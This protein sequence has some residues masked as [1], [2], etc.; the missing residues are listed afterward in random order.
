MAENQGT[1]IVWGVDTT[2][3]TGFSAAA[4][5]G[6]TFTGAD[7][8]YEADKVEVKNASG[9]VTTAYYYNSRVTL[10]LKCYPSGSSGS[11]TS[12]PVAGEMVTVTSGDAAINGNWICESASKARSNEGV[13]EFD[14]SLISYG[15]VTPS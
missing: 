5:G 13:T 1:T 6:Y 3:M 11:T 14:I 8:G 9:E 2:N 15:N 4:S 12:L 7:V 10:S